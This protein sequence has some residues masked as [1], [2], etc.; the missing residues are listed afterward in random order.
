MI[1]S[2]FEQ[3]RMED[4]ATGH[5]VFERVPSPA[6]VVHLDRVR[7]NLRRIVA[8][9]GGDANRLRPHVKTAKVPEVFAEMIRAGV[10]FFKCAT[11][12]EADYLLRELRRREVDDAE[13]LLAYPLVGPSLARA[14]ELAQAAG[15]TRLAVL[16]ED[17]ARVKDVPPGLSLFVDLNPG[18]NR[19]GVPLEREE[20]VRE[21]AGMAGSRFAGLHFYEGH[22]HGADAAARR[23]MARAGYER[24]VALAGGMIRAGIAI[25][26]IVTSGTPAFRYA[27][28]FEPLRALPGVVHRVSP[29]TV[30]YHD[31]R[32]E[33]ELEDLDL[34]PAALVFTRVVSHPERGIVTCD[35]GSKSIAAE[36]GDPCAFVLG[37]PDL[38]AL[39]P[40]EE[41]L[42]LRVQGGAAPPRGSGLFLIPRHVCPTVNLAEE[43]LL[44]DGSAAPRVVP[45]R[46]RAHELGPLTPRPGDTRT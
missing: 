38:E 3:L 26:E 16:C 13:V 8:L 14:G 21:I 12:R 35:A 5:P 37:H 40:S 42:P 17:P 9:A 31:L 6:L 15:A 32:S 34:T 10:R 24:L 41:H 44:F 30:I 39:T 33:Q 22:V 20:V 7:E 29:G 25:R 18:M 28:E 43:A 4:Y 2:R 11:T 1:S 23:S 46:A 45:V 36:A 19:T 27:L